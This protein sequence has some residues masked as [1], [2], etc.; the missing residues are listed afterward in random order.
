MSDEVDREAV[1]EH[2]DS[3]WMVGLTVG[4]E[5]MVRVAACEIERL[6]RRVRKLEDA[7]DE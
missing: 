6:E 2:E 1:R 4:I 3:L 7:R 5:G